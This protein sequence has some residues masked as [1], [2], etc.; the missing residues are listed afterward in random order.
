M[1]K[2]LCVCLWMVL[3]GVCMD[4][5]FPYMFVYKAL[6]SFPQ[7]SVDKLCVCFVFIS[8]LNL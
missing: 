6:V 8:G 1:W 7:R 5:V 3:S 4:C 2:S